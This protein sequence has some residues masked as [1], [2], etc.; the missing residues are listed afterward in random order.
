MDPGVGFF[1]AGAEGDGGLPA[2]KFL[3]EGVVAA[4]AADA[5]GGVEFVVA[6]E[7]DAGDVFDEVD[8][9]VDGDHFGGAEV[10]GVEDVAVHDGLGAVDA[11]VDVLEAAGLV[12]VAPDFDVV[13]A[14]EFGLDDFAADGGGGFFASAVEGAVGSVD[15]VVAGDAGL[16]AEVFAE[17]AAHAFGEEFFPAVAVFGVGGVGVFF[18]EAGVV[19]FA[20][21]VSGVDAGG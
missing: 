17:V 19:G 1:E 5:F 7:F 11:V 14:V 20:L 15:I 4:A 12:A 2:E 9:L 6:L 10:D 21:F 3:D 16:D 8:E 18:L 13:G